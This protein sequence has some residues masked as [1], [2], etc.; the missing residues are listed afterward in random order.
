MASVFLMSLIWKRVTT[1]AVK[2]TLYVGTPLCLTVGILNLF[3]KLPESPWTHY[4]MLTFYLFIFCMAVLVTVSLLTQHSSYELSLEE[5]N[6][7]GASEFDKRGAGKL[8]RMLWIGLAVVMLG[9]Y[10]GFQCLSTRMQSAEIYVSAGYLS[11]NNKIN[12]PRGNDSNP[13]TARQPF[14]TMERAKAEVLKRKAESGLPK[15]GIKVWVHGGIY[16]NDKPLVF[17]DE[18]SGQAGSPIRWRSFPGEK[19]VALCDVKPGAEK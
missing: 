10:V 3:N 19:P 14:L 11:P 16:Q 12:I 8:G 5:A 2:S 15:D 13:G 4:M 18:E 17:E 9:L 7:G 6:S 1:T